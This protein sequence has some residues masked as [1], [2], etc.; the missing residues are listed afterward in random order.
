MI[1]T[2]AY[3]TTACDG[4]N[5]QKI[6]KA[7]E[8]AFIKKWLPSISEVLNNTKSFNNTKVRAIVND[9]GV[10]IFVHPIIIKNPDDKTDTVIVDLRSCVRLDE[11]QSTY[12]VRNQF[13]ASY[14]ALY[15]ALSELWM[16]GDSN[17]ILSISNLQ[18]NIYSRWISESIVKRFGLN[19]QDQI[20]IQ[21]L[22]AYFY[23][24]QFVGKEELDT[25]DLNRY[26]GIINRSLY[27]PAEKVF[28]IIENL[29]VIN[30]VKTFCELA[31]EVTGNIRLAELNPGLLF[32]IIGNTWFGGTNHKEI[33]A[34]AT[35]YP[36]AWIA[37]MYSAIVDR[38]FKNSM[39]AKLLDNAKRQETDA[40]VKSVLGLFSSNF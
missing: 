15:G 25:N 11:T 28:D 34:V 26:A 32:A 17:I 36:P 33:L 8:E 27:I 5:N 23:I 2:S 16:K 6:V 10:P 20:S 39:I 35:E 7:L 13:E 22:A 38:S 14:I 18:V 3:E 4:F 24:C 21:I 30:N 31:K 37:V 40:F 9:G 29:P 19:P 12:I 1:L